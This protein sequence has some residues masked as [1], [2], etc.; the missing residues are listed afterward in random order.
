MK[1]LK[2]IRYQ[3]SFG[4]R[5]YG[6]GSIVNLDDA[7]AM[8]LVKAHANQFEVVGVAEQPEETATDTPEPENKDVSAGVELPKADPTAA[9]KKKA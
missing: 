8:A 9:I 5:L 4:G 6:A 3:L 2:V 1:K 7:K